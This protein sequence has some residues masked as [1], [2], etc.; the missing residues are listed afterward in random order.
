MVIPEYDQCDCGKRGPH[1]GCQA[2]PKC[3]KPKRAQAIGVK[4]QRVRMLKT[5]APD[6]IPNGSIGEVR[7][8]WRGKPGKIYE[9]GLSA[10]I[11]GKHVAY[12]YPDEVEVVEDKP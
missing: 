8:I 9:R 10:V 2:K 12:V 5:R 3:D 6:K 1:S 11:F 4:N 7:P